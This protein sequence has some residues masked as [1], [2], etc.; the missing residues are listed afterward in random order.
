MDSGNIIAKTESAFKAALGH[1]N[2]ELMHLHSGRA[3]ASMLDQV[4]VEAYGT[5]LP[6]KQVGSVTVSDAQ[7]LQITPFDPNNLQAI[8]NAIRNNPSLGLN[9]SDDGHVVR[10][11]IPP[12]TEERRRELAKQINEKL[13]AAIVRMRGGRHEALHQLESAKKEKLIGEDEERRLQK[14]IDDNFN[15]Y[16]GEME[17][18]AK[19]KEAEILKI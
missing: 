18:A 12:L 6:L 4:V 16:R 11:Q 2:E 3:N 17:A 1:L 8:A 15:R 19:T 7:M 9:P 10:L 14:S 5:S 13:E